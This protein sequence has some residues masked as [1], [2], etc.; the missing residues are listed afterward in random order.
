ML[1][2]SRRGLLASAA[3]T[4]AA[5]AAFG[6]NKKLN[7]VSPVHADT[8]LEPTTGFYKYKVGS[9]EVTAVYDGIWRKPHDPPFIKLRVA[10]P[11][12]L[13]NDDE[14]RAL[15]KIV[16]ARYPQLRF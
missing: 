2:V 8:P 14:C 5:T 11:K 16:T 15:L 4:A 1:T 13:P 3:A 9:I 10:H 7:F 12:H 6:L